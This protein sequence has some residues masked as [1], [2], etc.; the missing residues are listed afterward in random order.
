[1]AMMSRASGPLGSVHVSKKKKW[2]RQAE[3]P[4]QP[5]FTVGSR[6][7]VRRGVKDPDAPDMPIGGWCG[8]V[9]EVDPSSQPFGYLVEWDRRT[10]ENMHPVFV[11]R[12]RRDDLEIESMWLDQDD[13]EADAGDL[14]PI[15]QPTALV[16]RP[17]RPEDQDDR[18]RAVF[19]LTSD[20]PLPE[21]DDDS[22][23]RYHAYL[24]A[25]LRL[26]LEAR[27]VEETGPRE[28]RERRLRVERLLPPEDSDTEEGLLIA[29]DFGDEEEELPLWLLATAEAAPGFNPGEQQRLIRDYAHWFSEGQGVDPLLPFPGVERPP[30]GLPTTPPSLG[31]I[32]NLSGM[33]GAVGGAAVGSIT[34]TL[35]GARTAALVGAGVLGG[36]LGLAGRRYGMIFGAVNRWRYGSLAGFLAGAV[37]GGA[38]GALGGVLAIAYVGSVS[39]SVAGVVLGGLLAPQGRKTSSKFRGGLAGAILGGIVLALVQDHREALL[40]LAAGAVVGALGTALLVIVALTFLASLGGGRTP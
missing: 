2:R 26:P 13:L 12:C 30:A 9:A 39:G 1:M 10:L 34:A 15:E 4:R 18:V 20:D 14:L 37:V 36:L 33:V 19:G 16:T 25:H 24:A 7:R 40:G 8:T 3:P 31:R 21:V 5:A 22:L 29:G 35:D 27:I 28:L 32:L 11:K 38:L 23:A 17:L 6:V